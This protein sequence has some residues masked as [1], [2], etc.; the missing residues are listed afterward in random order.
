M[1]SIAFI[2]G[3]NMARAIVGGLVKSGRAAQT[4]TVVDPDE[5]QRLRLQGEFGV[6]T[7][8]RADSTLAAA[9]TVVWAV[10]PQFFQ[11]AAQGC[12]AHLGPALHLSVMAGIRSDSIALAVGSERVVRAMPNTPAL[13]GQGIAGL[14]ARG[15]VDAT[16]R[17]S[18][19]AAL[20]ALKV[21][22]LLAGFR[23]K[24]AG[25]VAAA[26]DAIMAIAAFADAHWSALRELDVNPLIV[27]PQGQGIVAVDALLGLSE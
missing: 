25:D 4:V 11:A 26:I 6:R 9:R 18:V 7:L 24:P 13:I 12:T 1:N 17:A 8:A 10:K 3:G 2:G 27:L 23:G 19:E 5:A 15:G 16:D 14:Y 20:M 21:S 22:R